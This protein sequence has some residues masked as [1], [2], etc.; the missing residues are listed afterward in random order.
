MG[1]LSGM[2]SVGICGLFLLTW[3][4]TSCRRISNGENM[5]PAINPNSQ[6]SNLA[7]NNAALNEQ[8]I[9]SAIA[10]PADFGSNTVV[11]PAFAS[12][13]QGDFFI[14]NTAAGQKIAVWLDKDDNGTEPSGP[15]YTACDTKVEADIATGDAASDVAEKVSA[16][17][18]ALEA[19]PGPIS[20]DGSTLL[21][22]EGG[23]GLL[24][25]P[26][27]YNS[28][29]NDNG[30]FVAATT[31]PGADSV[32]SSKYFSIF[33]NEDN[34]YHFWFQP[35]GRAS[36]PAVEGSIAT[37]VAYTG[38]QSAETIA[39]LIKDAVDALAEFELNLIGT[40]Q[41][42]VRSRVTGDN[43]DAVDGDSGMVVS[44]I[45]DG[46]DAPTQNV[47]PSPGSSPSGISN[48]PDAI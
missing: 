12:S 39:G 44:L 31:N 1:L 27:M 2:V 3:V 28:A 9:I 45:R 35:D 5:S 30:S 14:L 13:A 20:Q 21:F 4:Q 37:E 22:T 40:T 32:L 29:E 17:I 18:N 41:V 11:C 34:A 16:I 42:Q 38:A 46:T 26:S 43:M 24:I 7:N 8:S 10:D 47:C 23:V 33:D 36:A 25:A 15:I 6:V 19:W 48:D